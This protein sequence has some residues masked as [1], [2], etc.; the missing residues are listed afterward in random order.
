MARTGVRLHSMRLRNRSGAAQAPPRRLRFRIILAALLVVTLIVAGAIMLRRDDSPAHAVPLDTALT[1]EIPDS[2]TSIMEPQVAALLGDAREEVA[3]RRRSGAAWGQL[4]L[5]YDAHDMDELAEHCYRHAAY[6][7]PG[8]VRW[9]YHLAVMRDKHQGETEEVVALFARAESLVADYP[10]LPYRL[11]EAL[12]RRGRHAEAIE[13]LQRAIAIAPDFSAAHRALGQ[14]QLALGR[15][16]DA[17]RHLERANQLM[18]EDSITWTTL[19]RLHMRDGD[20]ARAEFAARRAEPLEPVLTIYD[21][22]HQDVVSLRADRVALTQRAAQR[23]RAGRIAE[24]ADEL[25]WAIQSGLRHARVHG[26]LALC[27]ELLGRRNEAVSHL[28]QAVELDPD[29]NVLRQQLQTL[30]GSSE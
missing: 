26:Q 25:H 23:I 18:P 11:G 4:A 2:D 3:L 1:W 14:S 7:S 10:P 20:P 8:D 5:L 29:D 12:A 22:L 15:L 24:A 6:L 13:A 28:R 19:A 17:S 16:D 9:A 21:P 30:T 27:Y